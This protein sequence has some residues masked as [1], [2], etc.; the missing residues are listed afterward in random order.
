LAKFAAPA[1]S[2]RNR[3]ARP[4]CARALLHF[5]EVDAGL[6]A[7]LPGDLDWRRFRAKT[8]SERKALLGELLAY[9]AGRAAERSLEALEHFR[10][11]TPM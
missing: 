6:F 1:C 3:V 4:I 2:R 5:H 7:D 8:Q 11:S 10:R 9:L